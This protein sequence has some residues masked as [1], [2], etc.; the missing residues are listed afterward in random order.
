[1]T[2][3]IGRVDWARIGKGRADKWL[4]F[5]EDFLETYD[6]DLRKATGSYYTPPEVVSAMVGLVDQALRGAGFLRKLGLASPDVVVADPAVG[7]GTFMLG[8]LRHVAAVVEAEEGAGAVPAQVQ[9]TL[10]RLIGFELQLGPFA[11]AQLRLLAEVHQ[12]AGALPAEA[13]H[14][15]VTDT[16]S[17]PDDDGGQFTSFLA[18]IA[19]QRKDANRIKREQPITVVIGNPP[20]KEKAKGRGGWVEGEGRKKGEYAPLADWQPPAAWGVGAHAKHLRNLYVY[21]WRWA[22]WK[23]FDDRPKAGPHAGEGGSGIVAF[24]TVAGFLSGPGFERMRAY[25]A[26]SVR[27]FGSSTALPR[28]TSRRSAP[29]SFRVYSSRC[30]SSSPLVGRRAPS[31]SRPTC[32]FAPCRPG[33]AG[34]S[35]QH[36]RQFGWTTLAP[37]QIARRHCGRRFCRSPVA[38]GRPFQRWRISSSTTAQVSCQAAPGSSRPTARP[39][40][41]VG[42]SSFWPLPPRKNACFTHTCAVASLATSMSTRLLHR[43]CLALP[44]AR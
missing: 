7:T 22:T 42:A 27:T 10:K 41:I 14:M 17:N 4:Y 21:F 12:L 11:V 30:A 15:Y 3:V 33:I 5:Y 24:I 36:W 18:P 32:T 34:T 43:P 2:R 31:G 8:V 19:K 35:S 1:M 23:V 44:P 28:G 37:G 25:C 13:V 39:S 20:Y 6:N 40:C 16:L 9:A 38:V 26:S 29:G